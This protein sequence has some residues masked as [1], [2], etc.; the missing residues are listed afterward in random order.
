MITATSTM[1]WDT[2]LADLLNELSTVQGELL[3]VLHA[4]RACMEKRDIEGMT[5]L[6]STETELGDRLQACHD[7][8]TSLLAAVNES[9]MSCD[10]LGKLANQLP[11]GKREALGKQVKDAAL[12]TRLM[13]HES[14]T[15]WVVAQRTVLHLSQLIEIIATGGRTQPTYGKNDA[16]LARGALVDQE[17]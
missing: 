9:G 7:R 1:N 6:A 2:E 10:T 16:A 11:S 13:Q 14:L 12:R 17:A 8:R 5:A 4:K 15:N 3:D